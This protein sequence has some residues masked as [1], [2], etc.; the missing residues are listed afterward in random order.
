MN[1]SSDMAYNVVSPIVLEFGSLNFEVL[2]SS[3][4]KKKKKVLEYYSVLWICGLK[5]VFLRISKIGW[6]FRLGIAVK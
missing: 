5:L 2:E 3:L 4:P 1:C 6:Y